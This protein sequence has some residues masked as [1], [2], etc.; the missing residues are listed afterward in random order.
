MKAVH[1]E[2]F[3]I[4]QCGL[5]QNAKKEVFHIACLHPLRAIKTGSIWK[6]EKKV[7]IRS[8]DSKLGDFEPIVDPRTGEVYEQFL[9][10]CGRCLQCRLSYARSWA[11]R[12]MLESTLHVHNWFL[13]ITYED[14]F[15]KYG[16]KDYSTLV[17]K[18]LQDFLKRLRIEL[19]RSGRLPVVLDPDGKNSNAM[20]F[21]ACGEYGDNTF[22]PHYHLL[23]FNL[24]LDDLVLYSRSP[25]GDFYYNSS[26]LSKIWGKGHVVVGELTEQSAAYVAR[27]CQK[28]VSKVIDYNYLGIEKE[29]VR[30]SRN[31]GIAF[32]FVKENFHEIYEDDKIYLPKGKVAVPPRY[33]DLYA[34]AQGL[35]TLPKI[36]YDR[37][38]RAMLRDDYLMQECSQDYL[39]YMQDLENSLSERAKSLLRNL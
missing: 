23:A 17:S 7:L 36:K 11:N 16:E 28:K 5:T 15:L 35:E 22:R 2:S 14:A 20:R 1:T 34:E 31:P 32:D 27:Y 18:D 30:M 33:F 19:Q 24:P 25:L 37:Q 3:L 26:F 10:P 4:I 13:T 6:C 8:S 38:Q 12:C 29:F 39:Q 9:V 21:Y